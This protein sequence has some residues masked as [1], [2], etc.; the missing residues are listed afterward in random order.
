MP[1]P[2]PFSSGVVKA[3]CATG[4]TIK[5]AV[6]NAS[7]TFFETFF[8]IFILFPPLFINNKKVKLKYKNTSPRT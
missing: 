4:A 5:L 1:L 7:M 6:N 2:L 3:A 8:H